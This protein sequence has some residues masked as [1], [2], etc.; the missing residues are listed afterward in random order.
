MSL[1]VTSPPY[2]TSYDYADIH[3]LTMLWLFPEVRVSEFRKEFIGTRQHKHASAKKIYSKIADQIVEELN[4]NGIK[5][6][7]VKAVL[8]YFLDLQEAITEFHRLLKPVGKAAFVIG[9]TRYGRVDILN[10]EVLTEIALNLGFRSLNIVKRRIP[11]GAKFLPS[12]RDPKTGCFASNN[13][14][15]KKMVYP[16]EYIVTLL[17]E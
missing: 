2:V 13:S 7:Y 3:Q 10:G 6:G 9:N 17:K 12:A 16:H 15:Q 8:N 1:I 4:E 14:Q 5:P 11:Y